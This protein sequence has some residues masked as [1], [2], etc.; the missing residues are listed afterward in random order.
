[1]HYDG[2]QLLFTTD[3]NGALTE[4]NLG[5]DGSLLPWDTG[6]NGTGQPGDITMFERGVDG[7]VG[8]CYNALN[9]GT[10]YSD[11]NGGIGSVSLSYGWGQYKYTTTNPVN[12]GACGA[13]NGSGLANMPS[14]IQWWAF[15]GVSDS[16]AAIGSG[17]TVGMPRPDG[18]TTGKDVIQGARAYDEMS[19]QWTTPDFYPPNLMDPMTL[20]SYMWNGN[21]PIAN[22]DPTG[23]DNIACWEDGGKST[24]SS[25]ICY[26]TS[27]GDTAGGYGSAPSMGTLMH[28]LPTQQ[29]LGWINA[30]Y[31]IIPVG[32]DTTGQ[33]SAFLQLTYLV[34]GNDSGN[35]FAVTPYSGGGNLASKCVTGVYSKYFCFDDSGLPIKVPNIMGSGSHPECVGAALGFPSERNSAIGGGIAGGIMGGIMAGRAGASVAVGIAGG[36]AAG[37]TGG[38]LFFAPLFVAGAGDYLG[39]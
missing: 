18:I 38:V 36:A 25:G 30:S 28:P 24:D 14:S 19:G 22:Q 1:L 5:T 10:P 3:T 39:C 6:Y 27:E 17:G 21:D 2:N 7:M 16:V 29:L 31:S 23:F 9:S 8:G 37:A 13:N 11:Q 20:K 35:V 15:D 32:A 34:F 26:A 33:T 4:A 12:I